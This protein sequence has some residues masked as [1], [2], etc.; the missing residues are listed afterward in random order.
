M[1]REKLTVFVAQRLRQAQQVCGGPQAFETM[2][3]RNAD[4][5]V[6]KQL[7]EELF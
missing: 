3:L 6:M 5:G 2:Y 7:Q 4:P 1:E